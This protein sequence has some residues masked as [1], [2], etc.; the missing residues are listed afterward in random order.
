VR[1]PWW[2][3]SARDR[4]ESLFSGNV[5]FIRHQP[6]DERV[7]IV[8][9]TIPCFSEILRSACVIG[10]VDTHIGTISYT[11]FFV[12]QALAQGHRFG[13]DIMDVLRLPSGTIYPALRR[14]ETLG[15]VRSE[16]ETDQEARN[17]ARSR[18]RYYELTK[19]GR[20]QLV[21]A[22]S[23]YRAVAKLFANRGRV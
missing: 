8:V 6:F 23:R 5:S 18:R 11:G 20:A 14:L 1:P 9:G 19:T 10:Y 13:F 21:E 16:W 7:R 22:E 12:L 3:V 17:H 4:S 15:L 2:S